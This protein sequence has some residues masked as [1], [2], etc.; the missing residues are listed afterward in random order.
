MNLISN[1]LRAILNSSTAE[2]DKILHRVARE[3]WPKWVKILLGNIFKIYF[4]TLDKK[5]AVQLLEPAV[6]ALLTATEP[7]TDS[8]EREKTLDEFFR[9]FEK[10]KVSVAEM[11]KFF[12][13]LDAL[14]DYLCDWVHRKCEEMLRSPEGMYPNCY[15]SK[16]S[17][18]GNG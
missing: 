11:G 7:T 13:H 14:L 18:H 5:R 17:C 8:K 15:E 12:G 3:P 1:P 2:R 16:T 4:Y 9:D 10:F 6:K